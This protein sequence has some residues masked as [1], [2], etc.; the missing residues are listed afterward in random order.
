LQRLVHGWGNDA[1]AARPEF[2]NA[3][4]EWLPRT[5]GQILECGSGLSTLLLAAVARSSARRVLS[6]EHEP[7]WASFLTERTPEHLKSWVS[8]SVAPLR[9]YRGF[10]W[11]SID[12]QAISG[13]IGYVICDGP[14]ASTR[15]G[16]YGLGP[17][18]GSRLAAGS[19]IL[20]DDTQRLEE[21]AIVARWCSELGASVV[22]EGGTFSAIRIGR[23]GN[24]N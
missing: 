2:L 1:W 6:L 4:L 20:L 24:G 23:K 11:Y 19:I 13:S 14:P 9:A 7:A 8:L 12:E 21:R 5:S 16:R 18:L 17:V 15:G 10:D 22:Q 3:V